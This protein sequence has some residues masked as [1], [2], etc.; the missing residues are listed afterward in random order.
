MMTSKRKYVSF[1]KSI[2]LQKWT[3][4]KQYYQKEDAEDVGNPLTIFD[5]G[6]NLW[7]IEC[8]F[9]PVVK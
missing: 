4:G 8:M 3:V 6:T 7:E 2:Y 5:L 1:L 9:M